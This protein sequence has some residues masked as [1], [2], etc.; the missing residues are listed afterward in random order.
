MH[1]N[2]SRRI[3]AGEIIKP[4][5]ILGPFY[6][7]L[8]ATVQGLTLFEKPGAEVGRTAMTQIVGDAQ[9]ILRSQPHEGEAMA[10]RGQ[11]L[12]W[13]LV[14][15]PENYL[16]W[17]RYNISNHLGAAFLTTIITPEQPG[18]QRWRLVLGI[19]SRAI[20]AING[21]IVY[22]TDAHPVKY[23]DGVYEHRFEAALAA[24]ENVV[25]VA[26]FRLGRMAQVGC[27]LEADAALA[28]RVPLAAGLAEDVR[29]NIEAQVSS[30]R[31]A[32]DVFYGEHEVGFRLGVAP[33]PVA[34]L[35]ARLFD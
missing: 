6:E 28:V 18:A 7:D 3:S 2:L 25:T 29:S 19:T 33:D 4:W 23:A 30:I 5:L 26:L 14:R 12:R 10:F 24:G 1:T 11:T 13:Q 27:R 15:M 16:S 35:T 9:A 22:D 17:G 31:L 32:R 21:A 34:P 20:V 8:S